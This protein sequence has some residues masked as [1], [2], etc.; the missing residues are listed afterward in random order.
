MPVFVVA[1]HLQL[2]LPKRFRTPYPCTQRGVEAGHQLACG[3]VVDLPMRKG[4]VPSIVA[5]AVSLGEDHWV[6]RLGTLVLEPHHMVGISVRGRAQ[7][8][9]Q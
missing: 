3:L 6:E 5:H 2:N 7:I 4:D 9:I 1:N 8:V